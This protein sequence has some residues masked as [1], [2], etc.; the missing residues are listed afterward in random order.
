MIK[1]WNIENKTEIATLEGHKRII[2]SI[3][4]NNGVMLASASS[5]STVK[6]WNIETLTEIATFKKNYESI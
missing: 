6:L 3:A 2:N 1:L 4:F 5:D